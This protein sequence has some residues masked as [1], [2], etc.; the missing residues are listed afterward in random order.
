V[1]LEAT[2]MLHQRLGIQGG[3]HLRQPRFSAVS[4]VQALNTSHFFA[5]FQFGAAAGMKNG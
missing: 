5:L 4:N 1:V 3:Q 2:A